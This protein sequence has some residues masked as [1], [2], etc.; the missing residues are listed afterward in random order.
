MEYAGA[1]ELEVPVTV[2]AVVPGGLPPLWLLF[3]P[4]HPATATKTAKTA[5][6]R[7]RFDRDCL[8]RKLMSKMPMQQ[9]PKGMSS[10][11]AL[12]HPRLSGRVPGF[13]SWLAAVVVTVSVVD[14]VAVVALRVTGGTVQTT[15]LGS[16]EHAKLIVPL[17]P[18]TA[19]T[20]TLIVPELPGLGTVT[21]GFAEDR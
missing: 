12:S 21:T 16:P 18:L 11:V 13:T 5:R 4:P 7:V 17:N 14:A 19:V 9:A 8:A 10:P 2:A 1:P 20:D 15:P 6:V 3:P